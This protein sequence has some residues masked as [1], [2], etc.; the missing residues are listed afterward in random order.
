MPDDSKRTLSIEWDSQKLFSIKIVMNLVFAFM[1]LAGKIS[2]F[3]VLKYWNSYV[4][5]GFSFLQIDNF[6]SSNS[7]FTLQL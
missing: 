6:T 7:L 4:F 2:M 1:V 5:L 3:F